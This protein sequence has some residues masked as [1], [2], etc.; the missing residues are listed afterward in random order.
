MFGHIPL[1]AVILVAAVLLLFSPAILPRLGRRFGRGVRELKE[2]S[3]EAGRKAKEELSE[4]DPV[5][6]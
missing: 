4:P 1:V 6:E 3:K 5:K 2:S